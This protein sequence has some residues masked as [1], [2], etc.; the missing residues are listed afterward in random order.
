MKMRKINIDQRLKDVYNAIGKNV[1]RLRGL[2][3]QEELAI[4]AGVSR[5]TVGSIELGRPISLGSLI[6][7]ADALGVEP[8]DLFLT[9]T[10]RQ[11]VS[12]KTKMIVRKMAD[13]L[14]VDGKK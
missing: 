6:R 3:E 12:H 7:I 10:D 4:K 14:G 2:M 1:L 9:D 8:A 11:E 13:L 5:Q